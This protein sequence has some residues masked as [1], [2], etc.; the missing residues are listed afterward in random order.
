MWNTLV[1]NFIRKKTNMAVWTCNL[2]YENIVSYKMSNELYCSDG[3]FPV[4]HYRIL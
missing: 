3:F 2:A 1:Y 4:T